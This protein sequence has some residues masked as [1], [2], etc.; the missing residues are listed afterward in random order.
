MTSLASS[1]S[2][3]KEEAKNHIMRTVN[4]Q[5]CVTRN[6]E[7]LAASRACG[8]RKGGR[9]GARR[10]GWGRGAALQLQL[11]LAGAG[12]SWRSKRKI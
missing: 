5:H 6:V 9:R 3:W 4:L 2:F 1:F 10:G 11:Q 8:I 12:S 7:I